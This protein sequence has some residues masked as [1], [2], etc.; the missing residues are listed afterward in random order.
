M[1][2][3][4]ASTG[5]MQTK[6]GGRQ[7]METTECVVEVDYVLKGKAVFWLFS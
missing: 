1:R 5:S 2:F 6:E 7:N 4:P 3:H